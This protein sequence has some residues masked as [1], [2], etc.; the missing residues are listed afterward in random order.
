ME[1]I[2]KNPD[3][4]ILYSVK[5]NNPPTPTEVKPQVKQN[6]TFKILFII[7][8]IV[9]I[10]L[11]IAIFF[12]LQNPKQSIITE[13][14]NQKKESTAPTSVE[15]KTYEAIS[16]QDD[17]NSISKLI[18]EDNQGNDT[19]IDE[20]KYWAL[21]DDINPIMAKPSYGDF[22]FSPD[23]KFLYFFQNSGWEASSSFLYDIEQKEKID[24]GFTVYASSGDQVGFT[25]DS[26]YFYACGRGGMMSGGAIVKDLSQQNKDLFYKPEKSFK[27]EYDK[28]IGEITF[29]EFSSSVT[30]SEKIISE[31]S[32]SQRLGELQKTK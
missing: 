9:V 30:E 17:R 24:L 7:S 3:N 11:I 18:L 16:V 4:E 8:N 28:A 1:V 22:I 21:G 25:S 6:N 31:Y 32:F 15:E 13:N 26:K 14:N 10:G 5:E 20:S 19:I 23:N 27:C 29:F 2:S 12:L